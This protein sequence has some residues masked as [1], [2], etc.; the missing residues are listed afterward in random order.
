MS[1]GIR[2]LFFGLIGMISGMLLW[3][4]AEL[5]LYMQSSFPTLLLFNA[6][7]GLTIGLFMGGCF[8][9]AE[10]IIARSRGKAM[11]GA[12]TGLAI[13]AAGGLVGFIAGQAALLFIGTTFF[14][15]TKSYEQIGFPLSRAIG[16]AVF[17]IF[18][19]TVEGIRSG[20]S[21][22]VRN[23][24]IG[25]FIG[26][27]LGG[28]GVEY[29]RYLSPAGP[30]ARLFGFVALGFMI[31]IFY[32]FIE[33]RLTKARLLLLNGKNRGKEYLITQKTTRVGESDESEV[34]LHGYGGVAPVHALLRK[35]GRSYT[36]ADAGAKK[37]IWVN[38]SK[39]EQTKLKDGDV[40]RVG[41]AQFRFTER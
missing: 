3:P 27:I 30:Y 4:C 31:G 28:F 21:S 17:G 26:G 40:L 29:I 22:K 34:D 38:D 33:N 9:T 20:S 25:G 16:W 13:G 18:I 32:G 36:L 23:G 1:L 11:R 14:S 10:G 12:C 35:E 15:S 7:L 24:V 39:T 6:V 37:G 41:D 19:G 5:I 8:G 2:I